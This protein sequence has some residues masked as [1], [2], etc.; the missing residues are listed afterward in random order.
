MRRGW[1]AVA[2]LLQRW[3]ML[4]GLLTIRGTRRGPP[5][6][7]NTVFEFVDA[8]LGGDRAVN[9]GQDRA[10]GVVVDHRRDRDRL[11]VLPS[12]A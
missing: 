6:S 5:A 1:L 2:E 10:P 4:S 8:P 11:P 3:G 9:D 7:A 12:T